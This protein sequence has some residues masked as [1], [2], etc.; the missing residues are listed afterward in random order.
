MAA[1]HVL[2]WP[3]CLISSH[4]IYLW[5]FMTVTECDWSFTF[6]AVYT[7]FTVKY[8]YDR[9][10]GL[11]CLRYASWPKIP[12]QKIT[13]SYFGIKG[14]SKWVHLTGKNINGFT[15]YLY[16][17]WSILSLSR[18]EILSL[19]RSDILSLSRSDNCVSRLDNFIK[20]IH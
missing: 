17:D 13:E 19:S 15:F 20:L 4:F 7:H 14:E 10:N 6:V 1:G 3:T 12:S 18:S 11:Q 2:V 16:L 8:E 9:K 5:L